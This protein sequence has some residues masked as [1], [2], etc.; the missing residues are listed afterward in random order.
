MTMKRH[1]VLLVALLLGGVSLYPALADENEKDKHNGTKTGHVMFTPKE[2]KWGQA[3]PSLSPGAKLAVLDGDPTKAG[4]PY[5]IRAKFPDGYRVPP[6]WH[7]V[8]ENVTVLKGVLVVGRGDKF[9]KKAGK[10][11][12][13]GSF[14]KMPKKMRHFA[15]AK[16]ETI[17]QVH[18]VGPFEI[19]YVNAADDPRKKPRSR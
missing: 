7:P 1:S 19:H 5:V 11:L 16:G 4:A 9:D 10:E 2:V 17:I 6:H 8:D 3:P 18:G 14:S 12:P 15:W 13:A